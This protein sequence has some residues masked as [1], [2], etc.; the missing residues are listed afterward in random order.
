[1]IALDL[2]VFPFHSVAF[3][4]SLSDDADEHGLGADGETGLLYVEERGEEVFRA[5]EV[6]K[7]HALRDVADGAVEEILPGISAIADIASDYARHV[8]EDSRARWELDHPFPE[9]DLGIPVIVVKA[10]EPDKAAKRALTEY[11]GGRVLMVAHSDTVPVIVKELSGI[12]VGPMSEAD[13]GILYLVAVPRFSRS[14][15][16]RLDLP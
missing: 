14:A 4:P 1:M 9:G 2:R 3:Q 16:T 8:G 6:V 12:E 13:Y 10:D 5:M 15:V 7:S 11:R